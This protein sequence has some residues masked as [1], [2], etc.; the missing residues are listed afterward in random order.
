MIVK[1]KNDIDEAKKVIEQNEEILN[2]TTGVK[3]ATKEAHEI[4][5]EVKE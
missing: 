2:T 1:S 5:K 4:N 3:M